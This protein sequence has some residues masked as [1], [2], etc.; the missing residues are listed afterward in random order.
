MLSS[1]GDD[2]VLNL[3]FWKFVCVCGGGEV[4][5]P[6]LFPFGPLFINILA[7]NHKITYFES[8]RCLKKV[9]HRI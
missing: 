6:E 2:S 7:A 4:V 9:K 1:F 8:I 5:S 3:S